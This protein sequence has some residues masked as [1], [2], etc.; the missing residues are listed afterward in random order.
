MLLRFCAQLPPS[1]CWIGLR[2]GFNPHVRKPCSPSFTCYR[3]DALQTFEH[4]SMDISGNAI[5]FGGGGGIG[6]ATALAFAQA[7]ATGLLIADINLQ[8]AQ[9]TASE[10]KAS[11][12]HQEFR[13]EAIEVDV[14]HQ[15]SVDTAFQQMIEI[16]R[17]IDYCVTCAGVPVRTP[18]P[19]ADA[20]VSEFIDAQNVNV[21]GTFFVVRASLAVMRLQD[22]RPNLADSPLRGNTRGAVVVLGSALSIGAAPSF[23]QYTTSK[24]ALLG[25]VKTA[26]LDS[27]KD[28]IRVNCVCPTWVESNMTEELE[29]DIPGIK[30]LMAPGIPMGRLGRPEEIAD[31]VMFLC[32]PR[33]SLITGASV[34]AD[35]G[36][37]ISLG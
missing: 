2:H 6:R 15:T 23:V 36:M 7:G 33:S 27:V 19:T 16:F 14:Q 20:V 21:T 9:S 5:I 17:R 4:A 28:E 26:A 3:V 25:L 1:L 13:A 34:V 18:R 22:P 29:R 12:Q 35:G 37:T 31:V 10:A 32:S 8:A 30:A 24:H 11:S